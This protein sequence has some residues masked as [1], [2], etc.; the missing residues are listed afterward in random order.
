MD[1]AVL[2]KLGEFENAG[3][4]LIWVDGVPEYSTVFGMNDAVRKAA[5]KY[6]NGIVPVYKTGSFDKLA[7]GR[8]TIIIAHRL[9]T[10]S[11][12]D[13]IVLIDD[14]QIREE[15]THEELMQ[16]NGR[17]AELTRFSDTTV[18]DSK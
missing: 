7:E 18:S 17:Y 11:N 16:M 1:P 9:S 4:R 5:E 2:A 12:A 14:G 10:I 15:G 3:G 6:K 8:T 13:R